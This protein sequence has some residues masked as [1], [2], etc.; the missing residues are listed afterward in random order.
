MTTA[1]KLRRAALDDLDAIM[2]VERA[3]GF[4]A[5]VGRSNRA[6][7]ED[8]FASP[9]YAYFVG[10]ERT[11]LVTFAILRDIDDAHGNLYLK[12]IAVARPGGGIGFAFLGQV[13]DWAFG[14]TRAYRFHLDCFAENA[15]AQGLYEKL[16]FTR[17][18]VLRQAYRGADGVRHDLTLMALLRPEWEGRGKFAPAPPARLE[19]AGE[20]PSAEKRAD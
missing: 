14:N 10:L 3:P 1:V 13:V 12:R 9:R 6:E 2:A 4:E 18:G 19:P 7:H 16:G 5:Y 11:E 17:D 15:R 20:P 8:M